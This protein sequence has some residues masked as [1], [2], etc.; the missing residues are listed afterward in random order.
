MGK[1]VCRIFIFTLF[2]FIQFAFLIVIM[3]FF[4]RLKIQIKYSSLFASDKEIIFHLCCINVTI[5][6]K[7]FFIVPPY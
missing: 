7:V 5:Y 4:C 2:S 1:L 6:T 3:H